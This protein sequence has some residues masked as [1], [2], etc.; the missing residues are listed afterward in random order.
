M[1]ISE[2]IEYRRASTDFRIGELLPGRPDGRDSSWYGQS[3]SARLP[4]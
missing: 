3:Y 4:V 2:E 1:H